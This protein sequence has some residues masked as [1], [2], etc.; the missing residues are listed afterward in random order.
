MH[1]IKRSIPDEMKFVARAASSDPIRYSMNMLWY[2]RKAQCLVATDGRRLHVWNNP[3]DFFDGTHGVPRIV[4]D[5][6]FL[7]VGKD[8]ITAG[9][10]NG[11]F[12]NWQRVMP[13]C[14]NEIMSDIE[15]PKKS[16]KTIDILSKQVARVIHTIPLNYNYILDL[17]PFTW[18]LHKQTNQPDWDKKS[19]V[20]EHRINGEQGGYLQA[21]I[22]PITDLR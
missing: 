2:D 22:M 4:G 9:H 18:T 14:Y 13:V 16:K 6:Y 8:T 7:E 1:T 12:P 10:D 15:I 3:P 20:F 19:V 5:G 21:V 17:Y 11:K